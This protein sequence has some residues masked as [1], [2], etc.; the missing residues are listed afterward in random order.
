MLV[1]VDTKTNKGQG[2]FTL[3]KPEVADIFKR[4]GADYRAD[5]K[6]STKQH[7]VMFD[8]EH[9]RSSYFG[10]HVD[11]CDA[12]DYTDH[13][14]NSCRNRHC[15]KCQ[16]IARRIWVNARFEDLL[17]I[18]YYHVVF[19]L[20]HLLNPLVGWN[21]ELI[22]NL[23]FDCAAATLLQFGRDPEWLGAQIGF[24]GIL[25]TWGG[26]LWQHLHLHFIVGGGGLNES[27]QWVEPKYKGKFLFPVRALS[28]VFR[29]KFIERLKEAYNTGELI[30]PERLDF[31]KDGD[32]F[33]RWLDL[34]VA[35]NWVV[36][37][38]SPFET[39]EKVIRYIGRYTHRIA[40]SNQRLLKLDDDGVYFRYKDYRDEGQ[41]KT[42]CLKAEEFI[43]RFL[44][45]VLPDGFHRIRHYGLFANG[46]CKA[47]VAE[48]R[49][50]FNS[51]EN[52]LSLPEESFHLPCPK[53][54]TGRMIPRLC[55]DR[56]GIF[57][58]DVLSRCTVNL[59]RP[60]WDTS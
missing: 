58:L 39:P 59:S 40:I 57:L 25:H 51:D 10:Y 12:C 2:V 30:I 15:P 48:I 21:R 56:Y 5:H 28:K 18:P 4:C 9:C 13:S 53:C 8:I 6:L 19:T 29:G 3:R 54:K 49:Q 7:Q 47:K 41:W 33:E 26:K 27:G 38:K 17:P 22:Y 45:H 1:P 32:Q 43:R 42:A 20:P 37:T 31:L 34:L 52:V 24:Y 23:L 60:V 55:M 36:F 35:R 46:K 50:M 44:M 16:G 11:T 14:Y